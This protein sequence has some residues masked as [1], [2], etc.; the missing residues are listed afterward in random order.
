[1]NSIKQQAAAIVEQAD[2]GPAFN[3]EQAVALLRQI[4]KLPD[5]YE[6]LLVSMDVSSGEHDQYRRVFGR[7]AEVLTTEGGAD[8]TTLLVLEHERNFLNFETKSDDALWAEFIS[9]CLLMS[10]WLKSL[11]E[12]FPKDDSFEKTIEALKIV[13]AQATSWK[14]KSRRFPVT[15]EAKVLIE[16]Q[17]ALRM[18]LK[19]RDSYKENGPR[20]DRIV[21]AVGSSMKE[22]K[23]TYYEKCGRWEC[24]V[25]E[26]LDLIPLE[27]KVFA[28]NEDIPMYM[29]HDK[30]LERLGNTTVLSLVR[31]KMSKN[32]VDK[33]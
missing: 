28:I 17:P 9:S 24:E 31:N 21:Y 29:P 15:D 33:T 16:T 27:E 19:V 3:V 1:M 26:V 4:A 25:L 6:G 30:H 7:V 13:V 32:K 20:A 23:D 11:W 5:Q 10:A 14:E 8:E 18:T 12:S 2:N 22:C